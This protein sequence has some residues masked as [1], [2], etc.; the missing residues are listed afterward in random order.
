M[1]T[2]DLDLIFDYSD[3]KEAIERILDLPPDE[4]AARLAEIF[5]QA[6]Y[7]QVFAM[8]SRIVND[9]MSDQ[10]AELESP[11]ARLD[12][13]IRNVHHLLNSRLRTE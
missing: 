2:N 11:D 4:G 1:A 13:I 3:G 8:A 9:L 12:R 10:Y 6:W 5:Q 7:G